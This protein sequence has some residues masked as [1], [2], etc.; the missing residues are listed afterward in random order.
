MIH[1]IVHGRIEKRVSDINLEDLKVVKNGDRDNNENRFH[2]CDWAL[3][4]SDEV[5]QV[6]SDEYSHFGFLKVSGGEYFSM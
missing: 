4:F 6:S 2:S 3:S 5:L 1:I